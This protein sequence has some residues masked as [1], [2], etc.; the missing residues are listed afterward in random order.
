MAD[1]EYRTAR[2][3]IDDLVDEGSWESWDT[4]PDRAGLDPDYA[5]ELARAT[6][7]TGADESVI[8][9]AGMVGGIRVALVVSDF[10]FLAGSIGRDAGVRVVGALQRATSERLAVVALPSSGGTRMQEG[11]PAFLQMTAIAAAVNRHKA[12][13]LPYLVYLR[14]PTT[15]GVFA[16]WGSQGHITW[17]QPG[18]LVGFLGPR[19]VEALT[20]DAMPDGVQTSENLHRQGLVDAVVASAELAAIIAKTLSLLHVRPDTGSTLWTPGGRAAESAPTAWDA[21]TATRAP[22]R[23]GLRELLDRVETV[24]ISDDGPVWLGFARFGRHPVVVVGHDRVVQESGRLIGPADLR[25]CRRGIALAAGLRLPLVTVID[26]PGAELS[27]AAESGGIAGE[28]SCCTAELL[29]SATRTVSVLLGQGGG[30]A[31]LALFPADRVVAASDAWLSPLPPEGA[32][33][34]VYRDTDHA[35]QMAGRQGILARELADR[36]AVDVVVDLARDGLDGLAA[37]IVEQLDAEV[38]GD[39]RARVLGP[40]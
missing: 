36:G 19:V 35:A 8:T 34:I 13:G 33:V 22:G 4:D 26:T 15:G 40:R 14:H 12:S 38:S 25:R 16:S 32:S 18:A 2:Q 5:A 20:G 21:V 17:A 30:G 11:T 7:R 24:T 39:H 28:I 3:W 9:G 31:A 1:P 37:C 10:R 29:E 27:A 6:E 23:V